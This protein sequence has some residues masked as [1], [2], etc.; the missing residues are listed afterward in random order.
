MCQ[1]EIVSDVKRD[2]DL[3][4]MIEIIETIDFSFYSTDVGGSFRS[5]RLASCAATSGQ[6]TVSGRPRRDRSL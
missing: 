5:V 6:P 3:L 4:E 2:I 1:M